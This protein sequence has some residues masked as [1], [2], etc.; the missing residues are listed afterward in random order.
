MWCRT[1]ASS[2]TGSFWQRTDHTCL[3]MTEKHKGDTRTYCFNE[4]WG[5]VH[6]SGPLEYVQTSHPL[7][8]WRELPSSALLHENDAVTNRDPLHMLHPEHMCSL[9]AYPRSNLA[10]ACSVFEHMCSN[11]E[12]VCSDIECMCSNT[13]N[14]CSD[15]EHVEHMS[16]N[17]EHMCSNI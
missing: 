2:V 11:I 15:I 10:R 9:T 6:H 14:T 17:I 13:E 1:L 4:D 7:N 5:W 16:S 12:H 8:G 3:W